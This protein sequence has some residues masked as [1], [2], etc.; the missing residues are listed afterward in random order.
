MANEEISSRK[1][2]EQ[3]VLVD[4]SKGYER[5]FLKKK[6]VRVK[7]GTERYS[8]SLG[9]FTELAK[10][11]HAIYKVGKITLINTEIFETYLESFHITWDTN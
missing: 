6:F 10:Q 4:T 9:S 11:A 7:E 1:L 3:M 8:M 5:W 2:K